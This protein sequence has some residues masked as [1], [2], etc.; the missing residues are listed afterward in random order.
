M[1]ILKDEG[2]G[3]FFFFPVLSSNEIYECVRQKEGIKN[4]I[5]YVKQK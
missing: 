5:L 2:T 3:F 4:L 1:R